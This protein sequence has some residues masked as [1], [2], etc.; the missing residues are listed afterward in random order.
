MVVAAAGGTYVGH[1][2]HRSPKELV[3]DQDLSRQQDRSISREVNRTLLQLWKM[4]DVEA[5]RERG[6]SR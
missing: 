4:E 5:L 6:L 1:A 2:S 3:A